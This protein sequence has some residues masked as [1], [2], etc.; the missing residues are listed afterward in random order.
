MES[1]TR[2]GSGL[3]AEPALATA[4]LVLP[5]SRVRT[6]GILGLGCHVPERVLTNSD[7]ERMVETSDEWIVSRTGISERRIAAPTEATSDLAVQAARRAMADAGLSGEDLDLIIVATIT[8]DY[9]FPATANL[10]QHALGARRAGAFDLSAGCAGFIYG[11]A[12]AA[13]FIE[14][15][16]YQRVL[17]VGAEI[18][19]R[20][21][22]WKDR[23]TCVLFGDGAGAA[24]L[25]PVADGE[26]FLS[27]DLG[28]DGG[29]AEM[30]LVDSGGSR[31]PTSA[32]TVAGDRH[33]IRMVGS[34]VYKFAVRVIDESTRRSLDR[35]GLTVDDIDCFVAHQANIRIIDAATKRLRLDESRVFN[36][37]HRYGNTSA[38]SIPLALED[39][40]SQGRLRAGDTVA[41]VGFGAGLSWASCILN[42]SQAAGPGREGRE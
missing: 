25:G 29:G 3:R 33:S 8:G 9:P 5:A 39:A 10:V 17:V 22:D 21:V 2:S 41:L 18:I 19:S 40:R 16:L 36:N 4:P 6:A 26:G 12:V 14:A 27:F 24:V 28:S 13:Q 20:F 1:L 38:A 30:L 11:L 31:N 34:E 42:W 7:L 32:E 15:G 23:S 37:V 35:A